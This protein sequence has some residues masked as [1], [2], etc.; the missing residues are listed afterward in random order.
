[1]YGI[2]NAE[3]IEKLVNTLE[4]LHNKSTWNEKLFAG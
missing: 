2:F 3:T 1:M 4:Q